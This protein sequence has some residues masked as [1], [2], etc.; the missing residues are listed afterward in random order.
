MK[1]YK[2]EYLGKTIPV[3]DPTKLTDFVTNKYD[4][5]SKIYDTIKEDSENIS[6][7]STI[8][9]DGQ[10]STELSV[11][12]STTSDVVENIKNKIQEDDDISLTN[13]VITANIKSDQKE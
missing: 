9:S 3:D 8:D 12:I 13:D 1:K 7:V 10:E 11:K 6:D 2:P 4:S 5:F